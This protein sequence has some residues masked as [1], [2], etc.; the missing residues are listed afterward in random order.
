MHLFHVASDCGFDKRAVVYS[1]KAEYCITKRK[2]ELI[3]IKG[4][5]HLNF[6]MWG[7]KNKFGTCRN[8]NY[9]SFLSLFFNMLWFFTSLIEDK[10]SVTKASIHDF[11]GSFLQLEEITQDVSVSQTSQAADYM[12]DVA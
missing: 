4:W 6:Q 12:E 7:K 5:I 8:M 3:V 1:Y 9:F 11:S 2:R 10:C